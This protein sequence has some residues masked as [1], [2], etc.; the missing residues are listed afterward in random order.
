MAFSVDFYQFNKKSNSTLRPSTASASYNCVIKRGS[1]LISPKI[2]LDIGLTT[3]PTWNYCYIS[4]FGRFYYISEW[5]NENALWIAN[6]KCDVL[7]TYRNEIGSSSLY[8]LRT[9]V[10]SLHDGRVV[11]TLY[12][13]KADC[14]YSRVDI[15]ILWNERSQSLFSGMYIVGIVNKSGNYGS[16]KYYGL[17]PGTLTLMNEYLLDDK[18]LEDNN[19]DLQNAAYALQ[20]SLIDPMQYVKSCVYLP[21]TEQMDDNF[22]FSDVQVFDWDMKVK[23]LGEWSTLSAGALRDNKPTVTLTRVVNI[24]KHPQTASRGQ[25]VNLRPFTILTL[26]IPPFGLIELDTTITSSYQTLTL[27]IEVDLPTGL[28]VLTI[29]CGDVVLNT[30]TAQIGIPVQLSQVTRD[31]FG[32]LSS[33]LG[34]VTGTLFNTIAGNSAGAIMS[35]TSGI[36]NAAQSL[37]PRSSSI[38]TGGSFS[39]LYPETPALFGQFFE[40]VDDDINHNGRPCCKMVTPSSNSG[41]YLI[42]DGDVG[43]SGTQTEAEEVRRY[44][45]NGFYYE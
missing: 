45:E 32:S 16:V 40:I 1:G 7:A 38:G 20:K 25:F 41:Y 3:A 30:L 2:E 9:S 37:S 17:A 15:P 23:I 21:F 13:T 33:A 11:D 39:Q 24:P 5:Y 10:T 34:G 18:L 35:A 14:T 29:K 26:N 6:L 43:I 36:S 8:A 42:Q 4:N 31:Y 28:G 19:F 22:I 27:Q 12:P 44:L